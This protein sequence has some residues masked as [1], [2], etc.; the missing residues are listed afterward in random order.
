MEPIQFKEQNIIYAENQ[1]DYMPLPAHRVAGDSSGTVI[2]CW[3]LTEEERKQVAETGL[4]WHSII[5]FGHPLQ[6]Q[7]LA[8][9]SPFVFDTRE[10]N[11]KDT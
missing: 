5:T 6:P 2:C 4:I 9:E 10:E 1:S 11:E 8:T 7:L 3:R